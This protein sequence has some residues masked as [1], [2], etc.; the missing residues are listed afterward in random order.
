MRSDLSTL[1]ARQPASRCG[2]TTGA[3]LEQI[4]QDVHILLQIRLYPCIRDA[5][6]VSTVVDKNMGRVGVDR[7]VWNLSGHP[8]GL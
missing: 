4:Q 3:H 5:V 7:E 1:T 8:R 6:C 2:T